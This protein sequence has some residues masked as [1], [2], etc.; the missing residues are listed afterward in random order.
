MQTSS[1]PSTA[2]DLQQEIE[3]LRAKV[4]VL[5]AHLRRC[6]EEAQSPAT[7]REASVATLAAGIAHEFNNLLGPIL[8]AAETLKHNISDEKV[9]HRLSFI[10]RNARRG[11]D[12]V[13]LLV[14]Y[15]KGAKG[16]R[17]RLDPLP[18]LQQAIAHA[19][20]MLPTTVSVISNL[21][22]TFPAIH[23]DADQIQK[24]LQH[25]FRNAG[26][27]MPNGGT[28]SLTA[29][30]S[31][32]PARHVAGLAPAAS[33]LRITVSDTGRG[34]PPAHL[35]QIFDPFFTTKVRGQSTGLG[36]TA[37]ASIMKGH[38]GGV[39]VDSTEAQGTTCTLYFP[40][41]PEPLNAAPIITIDDS[42]DLFADDFEWSD[43]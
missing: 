10:E 17:H 36:L 5:E 31:T 16:T 22:D 18:V 28:L 42:D 43:P 13:Q 8:M 11:A 15:D 39:L 24:V 7:T 19:P 27:A 20:T 1:S 21:P 40:I 12:I 14:A 9:H 30:V 26:E 38:Q 2:T 32:A 6:Q 33:Y 25:V 29:D 37:V 35:C 3:A 41:P 34:I 23:A 4:Q